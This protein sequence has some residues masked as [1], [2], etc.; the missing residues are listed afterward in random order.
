MLEEERRARN[1]T[2]LEAE[3]LLPP[4]LNPGDWPNFFF[5]V[6]ALSTVERLGNHPNVRYVEP[7]GYSLEPST[8][9]DSGCSNEPDYGI[10]PQDY[11][12]LNPT[13]KIPWNF[14]YHNIPEAWN[15]TSGDGKVIGVIDTGI[16]YDQ[17]NLNENFNSGLSVDRNVSS[18][19]TKW[20]GALW[21]A[22][23]DSPEDDC[24]HGTSATM[25]K[26]R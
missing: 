2:D 22:S 10:S 19:S 25:S 24:G 15:T 7:T 14:Y 5:E 3:D 23:L 4:H 13:T 1:N 9:S 8:R 20:S 11:T 18:H 6:S 21:W 26:A 12:T 16:G 17:D